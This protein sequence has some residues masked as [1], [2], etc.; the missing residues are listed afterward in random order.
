M[1][2]ANKRAHESSPNFIGSSCDCPKAVCRGIDVGSIYFDVLRAPSNLQL[3]VLHGPT[4]RTSNCLFEC[5]CRAS[6]IG[7]AKGVGGTF[8]H[9]LGL[10]D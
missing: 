1:V 4:C 7:L 8:T 3:D 6:Q 9:L 2:Y 5:C 10:V